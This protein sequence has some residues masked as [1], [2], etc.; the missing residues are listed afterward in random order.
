M[1]FHNQSL[2]ADVCTVGHAA[3]AGWIQGSLSQ[4][5][6]TVLHEPLPQALLAIFDAETE[7]N[8]TLTSAQD[9]LS[10]FTI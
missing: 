1:V 8:A 9:E 6:D 4:T 2:V 10:G 5:F 7:S 3:I